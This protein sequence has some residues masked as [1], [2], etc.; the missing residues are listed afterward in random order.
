MS[1]VLGV[2][3][4]DRRIGLAL[5][6]SGRKVAT[7]LEVIHRGRDAGSDW[8][9]IGRIAREWEVALIVVGL[10]LSLDGSEGPAARKV[11]AEAAAL[12]DLTGLPVET[13][14]ERFT[15]VSAEAALTEQN[16]RGRARR[17][18]VDMVAATV[19]LQAWL[20]RGSSARSDTAPEP[21]HCPPETGPVRGPNEMPEHHE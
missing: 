17:D 10:P 16:V 14:D 18:L 6:D 11:R 2:D 21:D 12:A 1:R 5:S 4:G 19:L 15:T 9:R 7:P 20:D 13:Y 8:D 3:P